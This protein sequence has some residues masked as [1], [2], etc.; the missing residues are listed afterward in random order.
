MASLKNLTGQ[1]FGRLTVTGPHHRRKNKTWWPCRCDCGREVT[2]WSYYLLTGNT[3]SCGCY[4]RDFTTNRNATHGRRYEPEYTVW[5]LMRRRC[6]DPADVAYSAYG[7]RGIGVCERWRDSFEHFYAD[8][9]PRPSPDHQIDRIDNQGPYSPENCHLA[10]RIE[11][12]NN[13]RDNLL[14]DWRGESLT[15][16]EW[17]RRTG[18]GKHTLWQRLFRCGWSVERAMTTP[19]RQRRRP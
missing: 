16:P 14:V 2:I 10:T 9:G 13:R 8:M 11:N 5:N 17:A 18:I 7:G 1:R 6:T 3:K 4:R 19:V 12:C 15:V